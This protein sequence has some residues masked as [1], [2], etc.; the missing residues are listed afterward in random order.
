MNRFGHLAA[1]LIFVIFA[2]ATNFVLAQQ[3]VAADPT[4]HKL[5]F[6]NDCVRVVRAIFGPHEKSDGMF[7]IKSVV[8]VT[9]SEGSGFKVTFPDGTFVEP[10]P[11]KLGH[12]AWAPAA[13]GAQIGVENTGNYRIEYLVIEPKPGCNN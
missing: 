13:P 2:G 5:V 8:I 4:H 1:L 12:V 7:D 9:L 3:D 6:E 10:V 11:E